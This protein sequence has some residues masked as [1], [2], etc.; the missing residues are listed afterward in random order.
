MQDK[1]HIEPGSLSM[2]LSRR[3]FLRLAFSM[4]FVA[5]A[6]LAQPKEAQAAKLAAPRITAW[7][8][9]SKAVALAWSRVSGARGYQVRFYSNVKL[10]KVIKTMNVSATRC[11]AKALKRASFYFV[12][13]R[14]WKKVGGKKVYGPWSAKRVVRTAASIKVY[15]TES[16]YGTT[17]YSGPDDYGSYCN[18]Y[19]KTC[20]ITGWWGQDY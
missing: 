8:P 13:V 12:R 20:G 11:T 3:G 4:P 16:P 14:A 7:K 1:N 17:V 2:K 19:M 5:S 18:R 9:K 15:N 10:K 6:V